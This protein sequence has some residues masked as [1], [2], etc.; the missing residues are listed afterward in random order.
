[1][2]GYSLELL[3]ISETHWTQVGQQR[4]A[5]EENAP[6]TQG[7]ALMLSKQA[8]KAPIGWES[9]GQ[10][11]IKAFFKTKKE[12]ISINVIQCYAP[13]NDYN[14]DVKDQ[15]YDRLKSIVDKYSTKDLAILM[16]D[17]NAKV[18]MDNIGYEDI[19][20]LHGLEERNENVGYLA[21][22]QLSAQPIKFTVF[23]EEHMNS[24]DG[25]NVSLQSRI[26]SVGLIII[27]LYY[28]F[29]EH[30]AI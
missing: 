28:D 4:L 8:Q 2:S 7:V 20:G 6:H 12:G 22:I 19:M 5:S 16:E 27:L 15:F 13:T 29:S 26:A 18:G 9:H 1:M 23:D 30:G 21:I 14:E 24:V 17:L 25:N 11:P 10:R 3:G